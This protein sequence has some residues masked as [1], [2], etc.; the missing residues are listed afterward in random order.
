MLFCYIKNNC[1]GLQSSKAA[2]LML[3]CVFMCFEYCLI[4]SSL[5]TSWV[6]RVLEKDLSGSSPAEI[7]FHLKLCN[8]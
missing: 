2:F 7:K 5:D 4:Q 8:L 6:G 1:F 3:A